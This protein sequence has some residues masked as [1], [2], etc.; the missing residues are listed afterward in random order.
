MLIRE[1]SLK[2]FCL[3]LQRERLLK[4][5]GVVS[6]MC[7][8]E[9]PCEIFRF[10]LI[11]YRKWIYSCIK[12]S[13]NRVNYCYIFPQ[14][15]ELPPCKKN[16]YISVSCWVRTV[17]ACRILLSGSCH[18]LWVSI[19]DQIRFPTEVILLTSLN[20]RCTVCDEKSCSQVLQVYHCRGF[21]R[22]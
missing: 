3:V 7:R 5:I 14:V 11:E 6:V 16:L 2:I 22:T 21:F 12:R 20:V 17:V 10:H 15:I 1:L 19:T 8:M 18:S 13:S 4:K 9:E